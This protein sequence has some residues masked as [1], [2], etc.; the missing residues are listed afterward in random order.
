VGGLG[1]FLFGDNVAEYLTADDL[2]SRLSAVGMLYIAD[3]NKDGIVTP[4]EV[5]QY[6]TPAIV[7]AGNVIDGYICDQ[8]VP[9][10]ARGAGNSW[11][12]DRGIDIAAYQACL[13]GGAEPPE[14]IVT[15]RDFTLKLLAGVQD[16][17][18]RIPNFPYP[19]PVN[20]WFVHHGPK[21]ANFGGGVRGS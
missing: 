14:I 2:T 17:S 5:T 8:I 13:C 12:K 11:L 21:V 19:G 6:I 4:D 10:T 7:Y 3:R 18:R 9:G 16:K 20:A 15:V 1:G